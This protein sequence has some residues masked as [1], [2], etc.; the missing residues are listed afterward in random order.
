MRVNRGIS[1]GR[2]MPALSAN[3]VYHGAFEKEN[4]G[5]NAKPRSTVE[6]EE[7]VEGTA[8]SGVGPESKVG[9]GQHTTTEEARSA[10]F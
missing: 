9:N 5:E 8:H 1:D 4:R 3:A 10:R 2:L 7:S 6:D